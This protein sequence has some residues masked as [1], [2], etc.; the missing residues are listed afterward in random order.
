MTP[1]QAR[2]LFRNA[3]EM[4][5]ETV[6][7][8]RG[9]GATAINLT[10]RAKLKGYGP[11][12]LVGGITQDDRGFIILAEDLAGTAFAAGPA[13]KDKIL[14]NGIAMTINALDTA[15]GR[16]AGEQIA[17]LGKAVG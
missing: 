14:F 9:S 11:R 17:F 8:R 7:L 4:A 1:D 12:D 16:V 13:M 3:V 15:T 2:V 6:T 5:G 10:V